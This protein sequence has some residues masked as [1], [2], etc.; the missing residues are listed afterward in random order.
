MI[1]KLQKHFTWIGI[2]V[3]L[4]SLLIVSLWFRPYALRLEWWAW[5]IGTILFFFFLSYLFTQRWAHDDP[6]KFLIKVFW[7]AF[8]IRAAYVTAMLYY[9]YYRTG[10]SLEYGA[11]DS[12]AYHLTSS[13]FAD[14]IRAGHF[15]KVWRTLNANTMGF[16]DQGYI[17]YLTSLY[18]LFGKNVLGPR[19]L[20]ALMS[21]YTCIA[22]YKLTA[23]N[24]GEKPARLATVMAV[25]LP[26][27]IHYTGTYLK[28]TELVFLATLALER[29]DALFHQ[30]KKVVW[31]IVLV[32][33]LTALTFGFRTIVGMILLASY[34][35]T[36][37]FADQA[38]VS[39]RFKIGAIG[40]LVAVTILFAVTPIGKE[41]WIILEENLKE[42]DYTSKKYT[43][44]GLKYAEYAHYKYLAPGAFT[45]PLTNLVEVANNNQKLMNG[46]YFVKNYLAFFAM[47]CIV[48][49]IRQRQ[50]KRF[51]LIGS[52]TIL[53][54]LIIAFS[55]AA[56]SERYHFPAMPGILIMAAYAMTRFR[57]KDFPWYYVYC[58]L[59]VVAVVGWNYL[60][61]SARGLIP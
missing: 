6:R 36:I 35:I 54:I 52:Y 46:S 55:F 58:G 61:L 37:L 30:N 7:I 15:R 59:L 26:Q 5:G 23:R 9:Y 2:G 39:K 29:F 8:L 42:S 11:A 31:N 45:L 1:G 60:K 38:V 25:F 28:E 50:V 53:Y 34:G 3:Y 57:R 10:I 40:G 49:A 56:T 44:Y 22:I 13:H 14:D 47:W 19:L 41:M 24:L 17:L 27:F 51:A 12:I 48:C 18:T 32:I 33:V 20:K 43:Y 21:A 4:L 16:S